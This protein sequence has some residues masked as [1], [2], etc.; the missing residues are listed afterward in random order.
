[1]IGVHGL[2]PAAG[3]V[4]LTRLPD[5][6][7]PL[8]SQVR[9]R[10]VR[11]PV[12]PADL[13]A[14]EGRYAFA[15]DPRL[16][17]GAEGVGE[18]EAVGPL[19]R[20]LEPGMRVLPLERG[21]WCTHRMVERAALVVVPPDMDPAFA[22][23][24]RINP[25]TAML[26]LDAAALE[27]GGV[28]LQNAAGSAVAGWVRLFA[29]RRGI[30]VVDI[31][32][33]AAPAQA[34]AIVDGPDLLSAVRA[35]IGARPIHAALDCV[36]GEAT[37]R[38]AECLA[39]EG[40]LIVFGHLSGSP[41]TI[42]SQLLTGGRLI[43]QGFSLRPAEAALGEAGVQA[44]FERIWPLARAEPPALPVRA[45]LPLGQADR[46]LALAR[47]GAGGRVQFDLTRL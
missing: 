10:M 29:A 39:P 15:L 23:M 33:R 45:V 46:A 14:L 25:A 31:I 20:D 22:A 2:L 21:N 41:V 1:M 32:R 5:L 34:D 3:G 36:A 26:L 27:P 38:L 47:E 24:M 19:V 28:L 17:L 16:P 11:A 7:S 4:Q 9:V 30:E 40:R 18:V 42:A 37:A 6:G 44:L 43:L 35:K 13:L 8:G 12:N